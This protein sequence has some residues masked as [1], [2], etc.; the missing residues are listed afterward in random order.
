ML[1]NRPFGILN[2]MTPGDPIPKL[3]LAYTCE[4]WSSTSSIHM[5]SHVIKGV[6]AQDLMLPIFK[7]IDNYGQEVSLGL[8]NSFKRQFFYKFIL[9]RLVW[10]DYKA[11]FSVRSFKGNKIA[12][13]TQASSLIW[14]GPYVIIKKF[15]SICNIKATN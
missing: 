7:K 11:T 2:V 8:F 5:Y 13:M 1:L 12:A 14:I 10:I 4:E 3:F 15:T 9:E 6:R